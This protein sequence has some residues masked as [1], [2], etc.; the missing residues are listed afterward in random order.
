MTVRY[1]RATGCSS[2]PTPGALALVDHWKR[3]TGLGSLGIF[4]CRPIRGGTSFSIHAEGRAA[5]LAANANDPRQVSQGDAYAQWL[6]ENSE[7][8]QVQQIIWNRRLWR[9]GQGWRAYDGS[10]GPHLDHL[11]VEL[12]RDGANWVHPLLTG[13]PPPPQ[14]DDDLTPEESN[15]LSR[16]GSDSGQAKNEAGAAKVEAASAKDI[17]SR[18]L[19][20]VD[21]LEKLIKA[22]IDRDRAERAILFDAITNQPAEWRAE[23]KAYDEALTRRPG[24]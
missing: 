8:L 2:G 3:T 17:A 22:E 18:A 21:A 12:N 10:A 9:S 16:I 13:A 7:A 20:K 5:D 23:T 24:G 1:D 19:A 14:E 4:N 15:L 6:T 11:H